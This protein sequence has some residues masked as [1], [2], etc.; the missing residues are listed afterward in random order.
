MSDYNPQDPRIQRLIDEYRHQMDQRGEID[1]R[2][3][4]SKESWLMGKIQQYL[5]SID[6]QIDDDMIMILRGII[7]E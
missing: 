3:Q 2:D 5:V 4:E 6:R 1:R 7:D